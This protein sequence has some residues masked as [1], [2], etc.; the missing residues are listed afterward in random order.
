MQG[1]LHLDLKPD[2]VL[3]SDADDIVLC[4][5]GCAQQFDTESM[6]R[7]LVRGL[8]PG[9]NP[10]HLSPEVLNEFFRYNLVHFFRGVLK[11]RCS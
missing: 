11:M 5:F 1:V 2:N 10:A 8:P 3:L 7:E 4:D 9:G 6:R